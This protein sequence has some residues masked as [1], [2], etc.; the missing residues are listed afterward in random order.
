VKLFQKKI[1]AVSTNDEPKVLYDATEQNRESA[2]EIVADEALA[3]LVDVLRKE[4]RSVE[5]IM[6]IVTSYE[7]YKDITMEQLSAA[8]LKSLIL[9]IDVEEWL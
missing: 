3:V 8:F 5:Q 6:R 2:K 1:E 9:G 4:G 7:V